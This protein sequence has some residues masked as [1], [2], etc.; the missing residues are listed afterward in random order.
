MHCWAFFLLVIRDFKGQERD[1][2]F[3]LSFAIQL[4]TPPCCLFSCFFCSIALMLHDLCGVIFVGII[5]SGFGGDEPHC[6]GE[7]FPREVS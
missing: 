2:G 4:M 3:P 5:A 7:I 1:Y 6:D